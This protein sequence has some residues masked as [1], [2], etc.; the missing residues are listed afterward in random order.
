ML[1]LDD[2]LRANVPELPELPSS[3]EYF[4]KYFSND[5]FEQIAFNT[6]LYSV[7]NGKNVSAYKCIRN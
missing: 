6:L 3:I 7:H 4:N 5:F 1:N 2:K